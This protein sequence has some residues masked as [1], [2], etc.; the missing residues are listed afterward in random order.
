MASLS[1]GIASQ[2]RHG[3]GVSSIHCASPL[4]THGQATTLAA[5]ARNAMLDR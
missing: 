3:T 1:D 2:P 5:L 4:R